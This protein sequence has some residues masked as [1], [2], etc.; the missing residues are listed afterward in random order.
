MKKT[1]RAAFDSEM[2]N[3][4][5]HYF[6]RE[7][8]RCY[9]HLERAHII[10]QRHYIPHV[11]SHFWMYKVGIKQRDLREITG[12]VIRIIMS[13][14]SLA[15]SPLLTTVPIGN[16]GRARVSPIKPMPIP[17]DLIAYFESG[18]FKGK[19]SSPTG[20]SHQSQ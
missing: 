16:T 5:D 14:A 4:K 12:Q 17:N 15:N 10:G 9:Y 19:S 2:N 7:Y 6:Q 18:D 3:A 13:V 8:A 1:L 11:I 20:S